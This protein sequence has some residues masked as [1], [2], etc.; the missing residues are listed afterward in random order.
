MRQLTLLAAAAAAYTLAAWMVAPGFYDGLAPL[1]YHFTCPP[2]QAGDKTKPGS[3]HLDIK[4][5]NG[6]SDA[7]SVLTND[8]FSSGLGPQ[9]EPQAVIGFLPGAFAVDGKTTI[10]VDITPL[11]TCP[12]PAGIKFVTNVYQIKASAPLIQPANLL[13]RYSNL[14]PDPENVYFAEDSNG[15]WTGI[16]HT[17]QAQVYTIVTTTRS[18]GYFAG[19]YK[20]SSGPPG[21]PRIG[22]GQL[23]PIIVAILIIIV[24]LAGLP[25]AILRRR[26]G[27]AEVEGD[28][29]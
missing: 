3:G 27:S 28:D 12:Q 22:G 6:V 4:V 10:S 8:V 11:D 9:L 2:P 5:V 24:V 23:L 29:H 25:L 20:S 15:P 26:R 19:G 14:E 16:G 21:S 13:L 7:N 1:A 17:Q 18:F